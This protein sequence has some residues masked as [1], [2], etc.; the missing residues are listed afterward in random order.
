MA[1]SPAEEFVE[2][3]RPCKAGSGA[4]RRNPLLF[5]L[6]FSIFL[7]IGRKVIRV[8]GTANGTGGAAVKVVGELI[9]LLAFHFHAAS[10]AA[11]MLDANLGTGSGLDNLPLPGGMFSGSGNGSGFLNN[12]ASGTGVF[13]QTIL[14]AGRF[15]NGD[16]ITVG[17]ELY[18]CGLFFRE[19]AAL[20]TGG[21]LQTGQ[22]GGSL[23][24]DRRT[25]HMAAF[26][27][28]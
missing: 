1:I 20:G 28:G 13:F 6:F 22:T 21:S 10:C 23:D 27:T 16:P 18:R 4:I 11:L 9:L 7:F 8:G 24:S 19:I 14:R 12:T 5:Q 25:H 17:M 2:N 26:L 3:I 15:L